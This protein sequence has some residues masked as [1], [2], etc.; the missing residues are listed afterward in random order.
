MIMT[1]EMAIQLQNDK[2]SVSMAKLVVAF[3]APNECMPAPG[4]DNPYRIWCDVPPISLEDF[5]LRLEKYFRCSPSCFIVAT[6]NLIRMQHKE[7]SLFHSLTVHKL[8]L[9]ALVV[10]TKF[11]EDVVC[12]QNHY[13]KCGGIEL[14]ELNTI[15]S[16]TLDVLKF[17]A[18]VSDS[19]FRITHLMMHNMDRVHMPMMTKRLSRQ[20]Y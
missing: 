5:C 7:P 12:S 20:S 17:E 2:L 3:S 9:G 14:S 15:E 8:V 19:E 10:A 18:S 11:C 1:S 6:A 4:M 16:A 13:A